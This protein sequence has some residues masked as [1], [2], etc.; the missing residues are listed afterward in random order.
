MAIEN[1]REV[2]KKTEIIV[3]RHESM[4]LLCES[5]FLLLLQFEIELAFY[6]AALEWRAFDILFPQPTP[7]VSEPAV[8]YFVAV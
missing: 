4:Y 2:A 1:A 5:C 6:H 7:A 8:L 3:V